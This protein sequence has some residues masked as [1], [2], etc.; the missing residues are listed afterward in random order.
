MQQELRC[1]Q[2]VETCSHVVEHDSSAFWNC[3]QLSHRRWLD[4]IKGTKKY[5]A[6]QKTFP[7]EG[8][9]YESHKLTR[10][11]INYDKLRISYPRAPRDPRSCG[12]ADQRDQS[13]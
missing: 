11:L 4:D 5:K 12:N 9:G 8:H 10:N 1:S 7:G 6:R 3:L 2:R 13:G